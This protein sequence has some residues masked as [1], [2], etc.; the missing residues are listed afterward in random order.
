MIFCTPKTKPPSNKLTL[1]SRNKFIS[2]QSKTKF[3]GIIF[4]EYLSWKTEMEFTRKKSVSLIVPY[5]KFQITLMKTYCYYTLYNSLIISHIRY[6]IV[7]WYNS[8]KP[9]FKKFNEFHSFIHFILFLIIIKQFNTKIINIKRSKKEE[10]AQRQ[11]LKH[12]Y[13]NQKVKVKLQINL[14]E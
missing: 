13:D 4:H 11:T 8:I 7:T 1:S 2:Q 9:Q 12:A 3:S 5:R 6:G 10:A 14:L